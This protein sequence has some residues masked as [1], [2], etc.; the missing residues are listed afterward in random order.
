MSKTFL[1][2]VIQL[3]QTIQLS[4]SMQFKYQ[5]SSIQT[6]QFS[7][8][9]QFS[10]IWPI[11][12]ALPGTTTP[13]QRGPGSNGNK[14]IL[15]I[16]QSSRITGTSPSD[17]LVSYQD[18]HCDGGGFTPLQRCSWCILQPQLTG[19]Y[20]ELNV[21]TVLFQIIQFSISMQ[22]RFQYSFISSNSV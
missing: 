2:Q 12:R 13:S 10:S 21:K 6:I 15:C 8:N 20:T 18:T 3:I 5:N 22:L 19:Q 11:D 17:C 16:P 1:C 7:I 4:I 9:T 14:G